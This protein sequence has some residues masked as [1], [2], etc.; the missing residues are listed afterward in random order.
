MSMAWVA[1]S[2]GPKAYAEGSRRYSTPESSAFYTTSHH[3]S[4]KRIVSHF[5]AHHNTT[6]HWLAAAHHARS[7]IPTPVVIYHTGIATETVV[8]HTT[9][10]IAAH[11]ASEST[12]TAQTASCTTPEPTRQ[13]AQ[14]RR[15]TSCLPSLKALSKEPSVWFTQLGFDYTHSNLNIASGH[16]QHLVHV[17]HVLFEGRVTAIEA[18]AVAESAVATAHQAAHASSE[19]ATRPLPENAMLMI[20]LDDSKARWLIVWKSGF[21]EMN[22]SMVNRRR[23]EDYGFEASIEELLTELALLKSIC[24]IVEGFV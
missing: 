6:T 1:T 8:Y 22:L 2:A 13:A 11:P 9:S 15:R 23:V 19:S 5:V 17:E 10:N 16:Y 24:R 7:M 12:S 21:Q 4:A 3:I 20:A 18:A 14:A